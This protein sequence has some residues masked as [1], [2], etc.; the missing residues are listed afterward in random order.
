LVAGVACVFSKLVSNYVTLTALC[1]RA[2][3]VQLWLQ[4][5][6]DHDDDSIADADAGALLTEAT[7]LESSDDDDELAVPSSPTTTTAAE[8]APA[9]V[10]EPFV[11][12][13]MA[14]LAALYEVG[15]I[16]SSH[17]HIS[18]PL[19]TGILNDLRTN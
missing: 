9:V 19:R 16:P 1:I 17:A 4:R 10:E 12:P 14:S 7:A 18:L 11:L 6:G 2:C 3:L 5:C 8:S 15:L 13:D